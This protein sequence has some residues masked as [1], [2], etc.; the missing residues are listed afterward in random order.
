MWHVYI[1]ECSDKTLYVGVT[2]S[3]TDRLKCH[4]QGKASKYTRARRPVKMVFSEP[5]ETKTSA[6]KPQAGTSTEK[7]YP[8]QETV[9]DRKRALTP[10]S[11]SPKPPLV[12]YP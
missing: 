8:G 11:L 1:L 12:N 3:L 6:L 10:I 5:H 2:K 4:N 9:S 7:A